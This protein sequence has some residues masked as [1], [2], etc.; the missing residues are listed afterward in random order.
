M[1]KKFPAPTLALNALLCTALR[2]HT[3]AA[4]LPGWATAAPSVALDGTGPRAG[5]VLNM[6]ITIQ[7]RF[8][9]ARI[10]VVRKDAHAISRLEATRHGVGVTHSRPTSLQPLLR[11]A[12]CHL[13]PVRARPV[14][15]A[16]RSRLSRHRFNR[17]HQ[18]RA[19]PKLEG[20]PWFTSLDVPQLQ[21]RLDCGR[22]YFRPSRLATL[23]SSMHA[24]WR[25]KR[26]DAVSM[27]R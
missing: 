12:N 5:T 16:V 21:D 13:C 7:Q 22:P 11:T 25:L 2:A 24:A 18:V 20:R 1:L 17:R 27:Y 10:P 15:W 4:G 26:A 6:D 23:S 19:A 8:P 3:D 14:V 9:L